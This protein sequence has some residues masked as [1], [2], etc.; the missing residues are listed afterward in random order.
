MSFLCEVLTSVDK[1]GL[2]TSVYHI[3]TPCLHIITSLHSMSWP[4]ECILSDIEYYCSVYHQI[5]TA[6]PTG[7]YVIMQKIM[8]HR[9]SGYDCLAEEQDDPFLFCSTSFSQVIISY[10]FTHP[11]FALYLKFSVIFR[12]LERVPPNCKHETC[13]TDCK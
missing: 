12:G 6:N 8:C 5:F 11:S 13:L 7:F 1:W 9:L 2:D 4:T 10:S 3:F